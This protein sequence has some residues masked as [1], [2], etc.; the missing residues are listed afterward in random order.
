MADQE[1]G[2]GS[3]K[4]ESLR[5]VKNVIGTVLGGRYEIVERIGKGGM[6]FV[7]KAN[8]SYLNRPVA[9][10]V[11]QPQYVGDADFLRRF[12]R[13]AQAAASAEQSR[14]RLAQRLA[15]TSF[16]AFMIRIVS[17]TSAIGTIMRH[18]LSPSG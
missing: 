3:G 1:G 11:L 6:A 14:A 4:L 5:E 9:V 15:L 18:L 10:K 7:Y 8:C 17:K 13:E 2:N 12:R 16:G